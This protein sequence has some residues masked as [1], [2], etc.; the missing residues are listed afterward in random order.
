MINPDIS[1]MEHAFTYDRVKESNSPD[2]FPIMELYETS[3]EKS[4]SGAKVV[5]P[6]TVKQYKR[7]TSKMSSFSPLN[8][9][10][11][12]IT[13]T[14]QD[15]FTSPGKYSTPNGVTVKTGTGKKTTIFSDAHMDIA[16]GIWY[17]DATMTTK[18]DPKLITG[19][20]GLDPYNDTDWDLKAFGIGLLLSL[21][22]W[23][24]K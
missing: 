2:I 4:F 11:E 7:M 1:T 9:S 21:L 24:N 8:H 6:Y 14:M 5:N 23:E 13:T 12:V 18:I 3:V 19:I 22:N 17:T 15:L 20:E 16:T 10:A